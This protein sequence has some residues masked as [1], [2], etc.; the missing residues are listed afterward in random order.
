MGLSETRDS[1]DKIKGCLHEQIP[2]DYCKYFSCSHKSN[3]LSGVGLITKV[4][5]LNVK[6]G[7]GLKRL[8]K[9]GRVITAEFKEFYVVNAYVPHSGDKLERLDFRTEKWDRKFQLYLEKLQKKKPLILIGD[10]NVAHRPADIYEYKG[11]DK[12][13]GFTMDERE[14]FSYMLRETNL[15][16]TYRH[17]NPLER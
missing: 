10:L 14:R 4:K 3:D 9:E 17:F 16:D 13:A 6:Y 7:I 2:N 8:D 15:F 5:P 11:M 12:F 1:L